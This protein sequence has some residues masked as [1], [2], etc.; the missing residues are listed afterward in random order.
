MK[1]S[2]C[3]AWGIDNL[4]FRGCLIKNSILGDMHCNYHCKMHKKTILKNIKDVK[5]NEPRNKF[6]KWLH[7]EN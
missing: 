1:C 5:Q 2:K 3:P 7:D 6:Y 4:G